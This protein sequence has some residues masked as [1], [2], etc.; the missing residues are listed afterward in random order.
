MGAAVRSHGGQVVLVL[1]T[2][3]VLRGHGETRPI[4]LFEVLD[5]LVRAGLSPISIIAAGRGMRSIPS[6]N[7]LR[8]RLWSWKASA[9]RNPANFWTSWG[10][11]GSA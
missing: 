11:P 8:D 6:A 2:L 7:A 10:L 4:L 3:E 1:D 9:R 5:N